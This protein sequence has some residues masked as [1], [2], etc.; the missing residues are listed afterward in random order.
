MFSY[1]CIFLVL[2]SLL[3]SEPPPTK[4]VEARSDTFTDRAIHLREDGL[5]LYLPANNLSNRKGAL[6]E[7]VLHRPYT[8]SLHQTYR[9]FFHFVFI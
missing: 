8:E 5:V 3:S 1:F 7:I 2:R 9:F 4:V 6:Y